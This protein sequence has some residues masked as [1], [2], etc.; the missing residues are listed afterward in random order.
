[1]TID[2][3]RAR[4]ADLNR[5]LEI[6]KASFGRDAWDAN[7]FHEYLAHCP[8]LFLV[9]RTHRR[10]AGYMI[11]CI[12]REKAELVSIAVDPNHR[13]MGIAVA[14]LKYAIARLR[15]K[16]VEMFWLMVRTKNHPAIRFYR[17]AGFVRIRRVNG[18]YEDGGDGW[19]MR[20]ALNPR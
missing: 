8:D 20:L 10:T 9:A 2:I 15:R 1:M 13:R 3:R 17:Q 12:Q 7:L 4:S 16:R 18:Y 5:I 19:R 14:L 6:E 11:A